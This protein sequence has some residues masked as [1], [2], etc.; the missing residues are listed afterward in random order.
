MFV[1]ALVLCR[2]ADR[3]RRSGRARETEAVADGADAITG[4]PTPVYASPSSDTATS[5]AVRNGMTLTLHASL[6][7]NTGTNGEELVL[8]GSTSET[9]TFVQGFIPDDGFGTS[10]QLGPKSFQLVFDNASDIDTVVSGEPFYL[11]LTT[12][13]AS[14][15]PPVVRADPRRRSPLSLTGTST[16]RLTLGPAITPTLVTTS[17]DGVMFRGTATTTARPQSLTVTAGSP[18]TLVQDSARAWH[19]DWDFSHYESA[20]TGAATVTAKAKFGAT[21]STRTGTIAVRVGQGRARARREP[22]R[23]LRLPDV[24]LHRAR[25]PAHAP[26]EHDRLRRVRSV[27]ARA[28]VHRRG[29]VPRPIDEGPLQQRERTDSRRMS[30]D[31]TRRHPLARRDRALLDRVPPRPR[32]P[33]VPPRAASTTAG[34]RRM[35]AS[36]RR[37]NEHLVAGAAGTASAAQPPAGAPA[38]A[39]IADG[40]GCN[41]YGWWSTPDG[42]CNAYGCWR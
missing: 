15:R 13:A 38:A 21:T 24:R 11:E 40:G 27:P 26:R 36:R 10:T 17:P 22:G 18:P 23:H 2:D 9:L 31:V 12:H 33:C 37:A 41:A 4:S 25:L 30:L 6:T 1:G 39:K 34:S 20:V 14:G 19:F 8:K 35:P 7:W 16:T 29:R 5:V 32:S 28:H 3:L 42:N